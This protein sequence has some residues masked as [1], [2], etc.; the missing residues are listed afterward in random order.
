M[1]FI[2][3]Y[4]T[5]VLI[6]LL[7]SSRVVGALFEAYCHAQYFYRN[8]VASWWAVRWRRAALTPDK[9]TLQSPLLSNLK[10][11]TKFYAVVSWYVPFHH[12]LFHPVASYDIRQLPNTR[13]S[14]PMPTLTK[15]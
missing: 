11:Y 5:V 4:V 2:R 7:Y 14:C 10:S 3:L 1:R 13:T 15:L 12:T 6:S 8:L 9:I